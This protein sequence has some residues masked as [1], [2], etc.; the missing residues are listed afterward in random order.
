MAANDAAVKQENAQRLAEW[1]QKNYP[2]TPVYGHGE[3]QRDKEPD[4]GRK[5]VNIVRA[6]RAAAAN[7][8]QVAA[9]TPT[10]DAAIPSPWDTAA[11]DSRATLDRMMGKET[12]HDVDTSGTITIKHD[13]KAAEGATKSK[14]PPFKEVPTN[15]QA[16]MESAHD[17]P[18]APN[19]ASGV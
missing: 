12:Q 17:G 18:Q 5:V 2:Q 11:E 16:T 1:I 15:R 8:T 4:E 19:P 9:T 13:A 6:M 10:S 14:L 7:N 3:I